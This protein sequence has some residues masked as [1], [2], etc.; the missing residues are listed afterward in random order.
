MT[1]TPLSRSKGQ[2][3]RSQ[4]RGHIV[5]ASH[6]ACYA[7]FDRC[8]VHIKYEHTQIQNWTQGNIHHASGYRTFNRFVP[9]LSRQLFELSYSKTDTRSCL[10][11]FYILQTFVGIYELNYGI[12]MYFLF[13]LSSVIG[14]APAR[15]WATAKVTDADCLVTFSSEQT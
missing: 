12:S 8:T 13:K 7:Q 2:T 3:S 1:R 4:G 14:T 6:T 9:V 11:Q 5:A 10:G 15:L